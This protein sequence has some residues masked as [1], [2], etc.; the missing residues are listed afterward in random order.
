MNSNSTKVIKNLPKL[1]TTEHVGKVV[2]LNKME[3]LKMGNLIIEEESTGSEFFCPPDKVEKLKGKTFNEAIAKL[4]IK[5]GTI[6][7]F[8]LDSNKK[9][10]FLRKL[11]FKSE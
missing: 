10:V 1:L 4:K 11:R 8:I 9:I 7:K 3:F 6:V 5:E 2:R